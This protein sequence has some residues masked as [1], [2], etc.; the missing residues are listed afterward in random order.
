[1]IDIVEILT[2]WYAGRSKTEVGRSLGVHRDTVAK[3][4]APAEA[5]G[6]VAGGPAV[7]EETWRKNA[8]E[9]FPELYDPRLS[10]PS[11]PRIA[12]CHEVISK[13][14]GVVPVSVIHQR[15]K[16]EGLLDVSVASLR[17]YV[18]AHFAAEVRAGDVVLWRPEVEPGVEAQVD[19]GY[20]GMWSD[21]ST[22]RKRR[23]WAFSMVLSYSRHLFIYPVLK[24]DQQAWTEAHVAAFGFFS[25]CTTR[26]V[27]DN[28]RAGVVKPDIYDPKINRS[29]SELANYYRVLVDPARVAHPKDK[30]QLNRSRPTS[31]R[32]SSLPGTSPL[33]PR[34]SKKQSAG[35]PR[36][37]GAGLLE[38]W[39]VA[40]LQRS[41]EPKSKESLR[42]C[43]LCPSSLPPGAAP[44]WPPTRT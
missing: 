25:G 17:R 43:R 28:F 12:P 24:M 9:W 11:E 39:R 3:Y 36:W 15:L 7:S 41:S 27:T 40:P 18:R 13:L 6:F 1:M 37:Q 22:G 21:P 16:D 31:E 10:R 30:P 35:A 42:R 20:L 14:V 44:W 32:A 26:I 4:V 5:E 34:W 19:Y 38:P 23:V 29:Y 2:H 33:C 8:R